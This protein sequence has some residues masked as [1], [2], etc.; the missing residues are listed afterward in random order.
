MRE[1]GV[2]AKHSLAETFRFLPLI[3]HCHSFNLQHAYEGEGDTGEGWGSQEKWWGRNGVAKKAEKA[4]N[5][6]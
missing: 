4:F 1:P 5:W 2:R 3:P 6:M